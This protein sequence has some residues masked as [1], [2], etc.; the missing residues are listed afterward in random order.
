MAV[1]DAVSASP[2][3]RHD[4]LDLLDQG[5]MISNELYAPRHHISERESNINETLAVLTQ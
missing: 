4:L 3:E 1:F 2:T 5:N